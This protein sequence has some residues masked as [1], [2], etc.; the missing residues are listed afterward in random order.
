MAK[1]GDA[2]TVTGGAFRVRAIPTVATA[3]PLP[4]VSEVD[5]KALKA[6]V[7]IAKLSGKQKGAMVC[8]DKGGDDLYIA[9]AT[10]SEPADPWFALANESL[11]VTP[12]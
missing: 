4:I 2:S 9:I 12:V 8:V 3:L 5:I 11:K 6:P 10:G 1:Y 7:N